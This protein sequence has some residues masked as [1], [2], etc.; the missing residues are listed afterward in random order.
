MNGDDTEIVEYLRGLLDHRSKCKD[1]NCASC[2]TLRGIC[3]LVK[4]RLFT[5]PFY[6]EL[7]SSARGTRAAAAGT[8]RD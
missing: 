7:A 2:M 5:S 6:P 3:E 8:V 1:E 4:K